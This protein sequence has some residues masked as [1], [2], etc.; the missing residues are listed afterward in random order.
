MQTIGEEV[1]DLLREAKKL[2]EAYKLASAYARVERKDEKI[3]TYTAAVDEI[4]KDA[5]KNQAAGRFNQARDD[6][7]N[8][9]DSLYKECVELP[10]PH[11]VP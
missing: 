2:F 6:L 4:I 3:I 9:L 10:K 5:E 1:R 8:L 7:N 11:L